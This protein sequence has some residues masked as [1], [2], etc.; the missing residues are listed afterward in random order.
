M[1]KY[2][3]N[4]LV[5]AVVFSACKKNEDH[6]FNQTPDERLNQ[7]LQNYQSQLSGAQFG[8]KAVLYPKGGGAYFFY[9][10]FNDANRVQMVSDFDSASAVNV[11]ESSYRLKAL[12]Q[13]SL[14]FDT[15]SYIHVLS[16]PDASVNGG[17]F[18]QGLLSDFE[19]YFNDSTSADTLKLTG[20]VNGSKFILTK[21]T[22]EEATG[23][24][25]GQFNINL[26]KG[27]L[28]QILQYFK[29]LTIG[30]NT[31]DININPVTKT[32]IFTWVDGQGN[33]LTLTTT[34]Y[35]TLN[36][37][38]LEKPLIDGGNPIWEFTNPVWSSTTNTINLNA[39]SSAATIAGVIKPIAVDVDAPHRWWQYALDA[40]QYWISADGFHVNGVDDAFGIKTLATDSSTY[41]YLVYWPR[42]A[43]GQTYDVLFPAYLI[44]SQN[45]L[46]IIYGIAERPSFLSDGR[47]VFKYVGD[48]TVGPYPAT[49]PAADTKNQLLIPQGYYFV[50][51]SA[52]SYDMVSAADAKSWI[53]W[54]YIF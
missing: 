24:T 31:Y 29:R 53:T 10:K 49:G 34:F 54:Q 5:A 41:Y 47:A 9:M 36:G 1:T 20:R 50:Q 18:G 43:A 45:A 21:A 16:D 17:A 38:A 8:W 51:T 28:A 30:T 14:I 40:G 48:L 22:Q 32:I 13:P 3:L 23:Y 37:I 35:F 39:G 7:A 11:K 52:T 46:D 26:F 19:F 44:T 33:V 27:N 15:Y 25:G 42:P 6:V 4:F 12:Q 2:L